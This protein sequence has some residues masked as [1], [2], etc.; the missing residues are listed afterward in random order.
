[1]CIRDSV[2][3][4]NYIASEVT[5]DLPAGM[6]ASTQPFDVTVT[7]TDN[8]DGTLTAKAGKGKFTNTY[9]TVKDD[10]LIQMN[11]TKTIDTNGVEGLTPPVLKDNF[12]FNIEALGEAPKPTNT[13]AETDENGN[14]DFGIATFNSSL[15]EGVTAA[16]DGSCLL[17]TSYC[18]RGADHTCDPQYR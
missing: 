11:G 14:V 17:Y 8:G 15:L 2:Y 5:D 10:I 9:A 6:T 13:T 3:T 7:V 4:V 18:G 1:M 12:T 16:E